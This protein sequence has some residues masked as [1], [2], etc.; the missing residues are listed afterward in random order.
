MKQSRPLAVSTPPNAIDIDLF[1]PEPM[2][3]VP[4]GRTTAIGSGL[5]KSIALRSKHA[6]LGHRQTA[7]ATETVGLRSV[8]QKLR[9]LAFLGRSQF[10]G[11]TRP[12]M[13]P[14]RLCPA[15]VTR[16]NPLADRSL[17][18]TQSNGNVV[19]RPTLLLEF[20]STK[21]SPF[22]PVMWGSCP[23]HVG[24]VSQSCGDRVVVSMPRFYAERSFLHCAAICNHRPLTTR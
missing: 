10:R 21:T 12:G 8:P 11:M 14:Q 24:I 18:G 1:N 4:N 19:L 22:F 20:P 13:R 7:F 9:D 17:G 2:A 6:A 16:M 5:N 15:V 3:M 23:S